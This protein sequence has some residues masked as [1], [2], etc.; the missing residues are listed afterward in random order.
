MVA[1][2]GSNGARR[3]FCLLLGVCFLI[4]PYV[5]RGAG[6]AAC[7]E[8]ST[9]G[10]WYPIEVAS[11]KAFVIGR[12]GNSRSLRFIIDTGAPSAFIEESLIEELSFSKTAVSRGTGGA[13]GSQE[14]VLSRLEPT[15]C[16]A[17][18][19]AV[20]P[21]ESFR[22]LNLR[23]ISR[24]EGLRVDGL[25]GGDFFQ[26]HVVEIDYARKR[27]RMLPSSFEYRGGTSV[28]I[29]IEGGQI[30]TTARIVNPAGESIEAIFMI[31]TGFRTAIS[32]SGPFAAKHDLTKSAPQIREATMGIG[33][34]GETKATIFRL[35]ALHIGDM[36]WNDVV[37][38]ASLDRSGL[39]AREDFA[40]VIGGD[41]LRRYR[42][43]LDYP[44][45]RI[46]LVPTPASRHSFEYDKSG[47]FLL[48]DPP[49]Y[50]SVR[51]L[52]V[53]QG[54]PADVA[55]I[56]EGDLITSVS[57]KRPAALA[58]EIFRQIFLTDHQ[59]YSVTI[60]RNGALL[61]KELRMRDLFLK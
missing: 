22:A 13:A 29:K 4:R 30:F 24:V 19:G 37:A 49:A 20:L 54:S 36:R 28:P 50:S 48:A 3:Y 10:N 18:A 58:L 2:S 11:N 60:N 34:G 17:A 14:V 35:P 46:V 1:L 31:D 6:G 25:I 40:G 9:L 59:A 8:T 27:I 12:V 26:R 44:H 15:A 38:T 56:R 41:L 33:A 39:L 5:L 47:L 23:D 16:Q 21:D 57:G 42:V 53:I 51:V 55:G 45:S 61:E 43:I 7:N 32:F 52:R